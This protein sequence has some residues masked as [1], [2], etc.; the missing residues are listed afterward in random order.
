LKDYDLAYC[1]GGWWTLRHVRLSFLIFLIRIIIS[2]HI[3]C[4]IS[5]L[6][7]HLSNGKPQLWKICSF[8]IEIIST[9]LYYTLL[10]ILLLFS[11][12]EF[13]PSIYRYITFHCSLQTIRTFQIFHSQLLTVLL[14]PKTYFRQL[15]PCLLFITALCRKL[16]LG[17]FILNNSV[18]VCVF[19]VLGIQSLTLA[20]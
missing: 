1:I 15:H 8:Y 20:M 5:K 14:I 10:G 7:F 4:W 17:C 2:P 13:L 18:C 12:C 6:T 3:Q 16:T 9:L 11:Q 19:V